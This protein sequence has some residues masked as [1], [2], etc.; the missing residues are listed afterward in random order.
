MF[1]A[2]SLRLIAI[3]DD[4]RDGRDGLVARAAAAVRGGATMIQLRLKDVPPRE[5]VEVARALVDTIP[6]PIIVSERYDVALAAGAAGVHLGP[7]DLVAMEVRRVVPSPFVIGASVG[8]EEEAGRVEGADY[9]GIGPVF[10]AT[11]DADAARA[12]GSGEFSRLARL[13]SRPAVAIGGITAA[14][15]REVFAQGASGVAVIR[16]ILA[17]DDPEAAARS[18]SSAIER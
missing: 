6:V 1:D 13:S 16:A 14:N 11:P 5:L 10:P 17:A 15:T 2:R 9:V 8:S 3:T 7:H 18:L 4:L 12:L